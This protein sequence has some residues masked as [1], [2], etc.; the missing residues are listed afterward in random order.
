VPIIAVGSAK[1]GVGKTTSALAL[2]AALAA[3]GATAPVLWDLDPN[4][5]AT[6]RMGFAIEPDCLGMLL[7]GRARV[8]DRLGSYG[9]ADAARQTAEHFDLV[10]ASL[11]IGDV[12]LH[13]ATAMRGIE[14]VAFRFHQLCADR[15][16]VLDTTPGLR[17]LLS[18]AAIAVADFLLIHVVP[19][20]HAER[21]V[22]EVV[23]ALHGLGGTAKVLVVATMI[24]S[25]PTALLTL[26]DAL[27]SQGLD[28]SA[29]IPRE[30]MV[31]DAIWSR[32]TALSAVPGSKSADAYRLL[33]NQLQSRPSPDRPNSP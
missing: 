14:L 17:T 27:A 30:A 32:A 7:A 4:G 9:L 21:H 1:G 24:G 8:V 19:E 16:V 18:R 23:A 3:G 5:D 11:D 10:P 31:N 33:A 20:P 28:I 26:R 25:D 29:V 13:Y 22:A 15:T 2:A 6:L 12:E